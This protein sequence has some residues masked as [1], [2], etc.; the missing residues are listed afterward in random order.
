MRTDANRIALSVREL[1]SELG[2]HEQ[3]I[4]RRVWDG[5]IP[6]FRLGARVLIPTWV[7]DELV[8]TPKPSE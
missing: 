1:A 5:T 6:S 8:R 2:V 3:T 4:W 7:V